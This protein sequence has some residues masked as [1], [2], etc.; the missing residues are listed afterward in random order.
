M[1]NDPPGDDAGEVFDHALTNVLTTHGKLLEDAS[2]ALLTAGAASVRVP[3]A[4][5]EARLLTRGLRHQ[6]ILEITRK[7]PGSGEAVS[8]SSG[9]LTAS[10]RDRAALLQEITIDLGLEIAHR[11]L[12]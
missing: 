4:L 11:N 1:P 9:P 3:G 8:G 6:R 7:D 10:S 12:G 2:E 5:L